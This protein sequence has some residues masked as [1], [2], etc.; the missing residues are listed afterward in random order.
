MRHF[1]TVG[2]ANELSPPINPVW[3]IIPFPSSGQ[4]LSVMKWPRV[5]PCNPVPYRPSNS[6]CLRGKEGL[7]VWLQPHSTPAQLQWLCHHPPAPTANPA[8]CR[9][10]LP[11]F[12]MHLHF[13]QNPEYSRVLPLLHIQQLIPLIHPRIAFS[14]HFFPSCS[15]P[16][17]QKKTESRTSLLFLSDDVSEGKQQQKVF[18]CCNE[19]SR[20]VIYFVSIS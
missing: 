6:V 19:M 4:T 7:T 10:F 1:P 15:A 17:P 18:Y 12:Q 8:S 9:F 13:L 14:L 2:S 16:P 3:R 11:S 20:C 5:L